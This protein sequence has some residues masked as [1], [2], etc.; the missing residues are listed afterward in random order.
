LQGFWLVVAE[1]KAQEFDLVGP[2][3]IVL[4]PALLKAHGL[5]VKFVSFAGLEFL[6]GLVGAQVGRVAGN[7]EQLGGK[8]NLD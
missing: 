6:A 8:P 7:F 2:E 1:N 4:C 5:V 3:S